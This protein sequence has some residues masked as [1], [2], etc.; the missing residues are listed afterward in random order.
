MG[1]S[2]KH[3]NGDQMCVID[4]ET[5]GLDPNINEI[6]QICILPLD[7]MYKPRRD[8]NPFNILIKPDYPETW[9]KEACKIHKDKL[10]K[11]ARH[12][13]DSE[14]AKELFIEWVN[15]LGLPYNKYR[16][17]R[18]RIIP[19]GH[20]YTFDRAFIQSWLG[21]DTYDEIFAHAFA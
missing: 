11:L 16:T 14:V 6:F 9:D 13:I 19:L 1:I 21:Q 4:T 5:T 3:W 18:R 12:G 10:D 17:A 7:S 8:V 2:C 20:N 15:K